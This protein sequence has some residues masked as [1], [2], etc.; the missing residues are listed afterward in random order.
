M[1][2]GV[3]ADFERDNIKK[4]EEKTPIWSASNEM[5]SWDQTSYEEIRD[6][7]DRCICRVPSVWHHLV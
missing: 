6:H 1:I 4:K 3:K 7:D 5:K 2:V